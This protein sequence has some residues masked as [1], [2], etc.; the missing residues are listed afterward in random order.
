MRRQLVPLTFSERPTLEVSVD[1]V[2]LELLAVEPGQPPSLEVV[3]GGAGQVEVTRVGEVTRVD[4]HASWAEGFVRRLRFRVPAALRARVA[5]GAGRMTVEGLEGCDLLLS[6]H[7]GSVRLDRV[8]GRLAISVDS[9]TVKGERLGG[10]F[11]VVSQAGS[12]KLSIDALDAG[13]HRVRTALGAV[14]VELPRGLAVR[15]DASATLGSARA[16]YP[17]TPGAA[18]VLRLEAELGSVLVRERDGQAPDESR[19][20]DWRDWRRLWQATARPAPGPSPSAAPLV[21]PPPAEDVRRVLELVRAGTVSPDEA[22][23]LLRAMIGSPAPASVSAPAA[24]AEPAP[25]P[26]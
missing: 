14:K 13:E 11:D 18:T 12:V 22:E 1:A 19:H 8:H 2:D 23:R 17:S 20:G 7:A 21:T 5:G 10:T 16:L 6:A 4:V 26:A 9:G 24:P 15:I 25:P 3:G